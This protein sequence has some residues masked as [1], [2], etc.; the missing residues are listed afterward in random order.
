MEVKYPG[1]EVKLLGEN[2]NAFNLI[3]ITANAIRKHAG[4]KAAEEFLVESMTQKS[5]DL[6]LAYIQRT[7]IVV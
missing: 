1:L 4:N 3:G 7:V 5:Y 6:L 2:G